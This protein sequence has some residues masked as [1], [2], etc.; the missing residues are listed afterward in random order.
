MAPLIKVRTCTVGVCFTKGDR[1]QWL[2]SLES[3]AAFNAAATAKFTE[4]GFE[5]QTTRS[6]HQLIRGVGGQRIRCQRDSSGLPRD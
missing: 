4:A 5:V 2:K 6:C 1:K 3:A